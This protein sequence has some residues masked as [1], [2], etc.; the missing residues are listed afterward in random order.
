MVEKESVMKPYR[1]V[2]TVVGMVFV[3]LAAAGAFLVP[4]VPDAIV[5]EERQSG[6][7]LG[8]RIHLCVVVAAMAGIAR[9]VSGGGMERLSG[10]ARWVG[11]WHGMVL[12]AVAGGALLGSVLFPLVGSLL[13]IDRTFGEFM[14]AGLRDGGFYILIWAPGGALVLCAIIA[15]QDRKERFQPPQT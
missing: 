7:T 8:L 1:N 6:I 3:V 5:P 4:F 10:A 13:S 11:L 14:R 12:G 9:F 2:A 15:A